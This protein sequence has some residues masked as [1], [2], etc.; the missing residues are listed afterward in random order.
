MVPNCNQRL[1]QPILWIVTVFATYW[2]R[3]TAVYVL[4]VAITRLQLPTHPL[5]SATC[6]ITVAVKIVAQNPAVLAS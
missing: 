6:D 3:S 4:M 5:I 1:S 2:T